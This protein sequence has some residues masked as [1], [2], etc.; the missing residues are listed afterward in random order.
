MQLTRPAWRKVPQVIAVFW[1]IKVLTT[2]MGEATSDY[3]V[4]QIDPVVA[5]LLGTA[6]L[7]I[8]MALQLAVRR[9][10]AA[11]YWLAVTMVAV[12]G[13]MAADVIHIVLGVPYAVSAAGFAI[14]LAAVFAV[15]YRTE[16]TLSI[17]SICTLRRELFY[18]LT[19]I[20]TF[21]LGTAVGDLTAYTLHLGFLASGLV[22]AAAFAVPG[23]AWR[24]FGLNAVAAFWCAYIL[25]RP[26]GASFADWMGVPR[27]L[28]GLNWGRGTVSVGLTLLILALVGYISVTRVDVERDVAARPAVNPA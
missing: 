3:S 18:W 4:H 14:A 20:T 17:H 1:V 26:F 6:G 9:Y 27:G 19:V 10:I 15:W 5:V 21:A 28:S 8:A 23:V 25:T 2:A 12:V 11:V 7:V 22:F 13:T 24:F 16:G